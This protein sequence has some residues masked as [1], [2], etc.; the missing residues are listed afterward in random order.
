M[1]RSQQ[2]DEMR[3]ELI[4]NGND[5]WLA[6][7]PFLQEFNPTGNGMLVVLNNAIHTSNS[8]SAGVERAHRNIT[9]TVPLMQHW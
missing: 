3:K 8:F 1:F 4:T 5:V 9:N 6:G 2:W 7:D